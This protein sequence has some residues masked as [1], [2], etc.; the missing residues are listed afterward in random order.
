MTEPLEPR[1]LLTAEIVGTVLTITG[2]PDRDVIS[3]DHTES[4]EKFRVRENRV[5]T[6]LDGAGVTAIAIDVGDGDDQVRVGF[7]LVPTTVTAGDG[8]DVVTCGYTPVTLLGGDGKDRLYGGYSSDFIDG[9][10]GNDAVFAS[11]GADTIYGNDGRDTLHGEEVS[12]TIYGGTADQ[13]DDG[14]ADT[15]S[16]GDGPRNAAFFEQ[17]LDKVRGFKKENRFPVTYPP[18]P[19]GSTPITPNPLTINDVFAFLSGKQ[20]AV[21]VFLT[22]P[23]AVVVDWGT[24][25]QSAPN[26]FAV[27]IQS[28]VP[29]GGGTP[30]PTTLEH[31]Y[32]FGTLK[33]GDY[34]F[35]IDTGTGSPFVFAFVVPISNT[36][37]PLAPITV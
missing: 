13:P 6:I 33:S 3:I 26:A 12:D 23:T 18:I 34:T 27:T 22:F 11:A 20:A 31:N 2:T 37:P 16:G 5:D 19:A 10:Q 30:A 15:L 25:T 29:P 4:G 17:G 1:T 32:L 36:E 21:R 8:D 28:A 9:G 24:V 14:F 35:T 7:D